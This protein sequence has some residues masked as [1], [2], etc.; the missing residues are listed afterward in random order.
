V[1][2]TDFTARES[3]IREGEQAVAAQAVAIAAIVDHARQN[4]AGMGVAATP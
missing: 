2:S 1:G 3:A 4:L